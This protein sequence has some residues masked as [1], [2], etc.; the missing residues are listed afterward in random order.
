MK[1]IVSSTVAAA[2]LG[3]A[4]AF[5]QSAG[6][7]MLKAGVNNIDPHVK[8][9]DLSPPSLPG[10]KIDVK[11]ATSVILTGTYMWTDHVSI[12]GYVGLGYEHDIV[13][14][15]AI[16]GV[17][18]IASVKQ[19]SPTVFAQYRFL[20]PTSNWRPYVGLGITYAHFYGE[21]GT[22]TLTAL[23]NPG[24][25]PTR[26]S[27]DSAWGVSPQVG[28]TVLLKDRWYVDAS[29][30]KTYIKTTGHLSTGQ[31]IDHRL[32]P[33]STNVSLGYRF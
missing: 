19:V 30:I 25:A 11:E 32:D 9:D 22:G 1:R 5:A 29:V 7:W 12:E 15:G 4:P 23:T 24:G 20:A 33:L 31:S 21:K 6:T 13:G 8:S 10:T 16:A 18:K 2:L 14:A 26:V 27:V 3:A 28:V 17:G